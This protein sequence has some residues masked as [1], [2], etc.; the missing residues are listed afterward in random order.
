VA[1]TR[2]ITIEEAAETYGVS[3]R[4][5][6]RYI[7]SGR[8]TARRLGPRLIRLDADE[9]RAQILGPAGPAT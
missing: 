9:V 4:T 5:I 7:S 2:V 1:N 8:I 3:T 6:R